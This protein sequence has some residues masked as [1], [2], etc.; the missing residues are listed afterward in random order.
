[1]DGEGSRNIPYQKLENDQA[2]IV[3]TMSHAI[4]QQDPVSNYSPSPPDARDKN[5]DQPSSCTTHPLL[6]EHPHVGPR[7]ALVDDGVVGQHCECL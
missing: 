5:E 4:W 2:G 7:G 6:A 3:Q 1:M